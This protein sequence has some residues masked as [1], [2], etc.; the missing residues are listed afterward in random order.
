MDQ[1][2]DYPGSALLRTH[3]SDGHGHEVVRLGLDAKSAKQRVGEL[4]CRTCSEATESHDE[5]I[6][7]AGRQ[8]GRILN[9]AVGVYERAEEILVVADYC[10]ACSSGKLNRP[11][12]R[13]GGRAVYLHAVLS[14]KL[15]L[16]I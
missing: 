1:Y 7:E 6:L 9:R 14:L 2:Q 4:P 5:A 15:Q 16:F 8:H 11:D 10:D 13:L 12:T 3:H